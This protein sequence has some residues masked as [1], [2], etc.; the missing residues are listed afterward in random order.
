M[1][2]ITES[3]HY[4]WNANQLQKYLPVM[5][6]ASAESANT[7]VVVFTADLCLQFECF[8]GAA[9]TLATQLLDTVL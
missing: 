5:N 3:L 2:S 7:P 9:F 6:L 8:D 4:N 1:N